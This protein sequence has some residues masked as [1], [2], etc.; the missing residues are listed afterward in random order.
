[1]LGHA[2]A[3]RTLDV[4]AGLFTDDLDSVAERLDAAAAQSRADCLRTADVALG[5][6]NEEGL[7]R[8]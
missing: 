1:M 7:A 5:G 2:S 6:P 3:A 8:R 4:Y